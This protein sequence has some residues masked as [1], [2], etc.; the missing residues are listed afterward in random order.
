MQPTT[1]HDDL[2]PAM[3]GVRSSQPELQRGPLAIV[4]GCGHVGLPLG[5]AFARQG[6][7]VDLI[8]ASPE[9]VGLVNKGRMPFHEDDA[10]ALLAES[11]TQGLLKATTDI[12]PMQ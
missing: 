5:L 8:D 10:H 4:G 1:S 12:S 3:D 9:R 6:F 2:M 7:Q 11:V